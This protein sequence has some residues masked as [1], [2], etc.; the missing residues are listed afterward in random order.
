MVLTTHSHSD[1]VKNRRQGFRCQLLDAKGVLAHPY[2]TQGICNPSTAISDA[3]GKRSHKSFFRSTRSPQGSCGPDL[4]G[5][6]IFSS[7]ALMCLLCASTPESPACVWVWMS[8]SREKEVP[9]VSGKDTVW[10]GD[11]RTQVQTSWENR[12]W[13]H[14]VGQGAAGRLADNFIQHHWQ[15][16]KIQ[17]N[18]VE[19]ILA[20]FSSRRP[21]G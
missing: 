10:T 15:G 3:E 16:I 12:R 5:W 20:S 13:R 4:G 8:A 6:L 19:R 21:I 7:R 11:A 14:A 18:K 17:D 2:S 1:F 9:P